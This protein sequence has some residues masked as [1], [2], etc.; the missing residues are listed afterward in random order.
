[1]ND[2]WEKKRGGE[3]KN[4]FYAVFAHEVKTHLWT[5]LLCWICAGGIMDVLF[6]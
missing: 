5:L 2:N 1:M 3:V 4:V 6:W